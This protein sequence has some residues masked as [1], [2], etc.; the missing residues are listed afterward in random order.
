MKDGKNGHLTI[1]GNGAQYQEYER[2]AATWGLQY[3]VTFLP[4][5]PYHRL[6]KMIDESEIVVAPHLWVEPFGRNVI[7]GMARGK[8]VIA[9]NIGGPAELINLKGA[10]GLLFERGSVDG[11]VRAIEHVFEMSI[12]DKKEMGVAARDFVRDNLNME[13]IAKSHEQF[14]TE[15]I[16]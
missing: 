14:Y 5:V 10:A 6:Q 13:K 4:H 2:L 3:R 8:I 12:F 15:V 1:V 11:L 9:S 7:E 16:G